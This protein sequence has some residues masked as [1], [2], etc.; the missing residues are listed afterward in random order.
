MHGLTTS[1]DHAALSGYTHRAGVGA[2]WRGGVE[3]IAGVATTNCRPHMQR[4]AEPSRVLDGT[5][6]KG[7]ERGV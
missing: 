1:D 5:P 7:S 2:R 4:R 3:S 6:L